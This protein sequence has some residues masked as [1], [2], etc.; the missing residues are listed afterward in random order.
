MPISVAK[1]IKQIEKLFMAMNITDASHMQV[2]LLNYAGGKV[3]D[4]FDMLVLPADPP[5]EE[6]VTVLKNHFESQ[7]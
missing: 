6:K 5:E 2:F 1:W 7:K 3:N 4:I